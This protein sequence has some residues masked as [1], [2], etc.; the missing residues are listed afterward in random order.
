MNPG[1]SGALQAVLSGSCSCS[2]EEQCSDAAISHL[3]PLCW[4]N[5]Q[6]ER[7]KPGVRIAKALAG[8][9]FLEGGCLTGS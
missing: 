6:E 8:S 4:L 9:H 3:S 1:F 7:I 5:I 2:Q